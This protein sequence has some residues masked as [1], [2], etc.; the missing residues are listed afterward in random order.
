MNCSENKKQDEK[1]YDGI[2]FLENKNN[3]SQEQAY[4][5]WTLDDNCI[6]NPPITIPENT[7]EKDYRW[8]EEINSWHETEA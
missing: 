7:N 5:S 8:N 4:P 6:W 2:H 1:L 3:F